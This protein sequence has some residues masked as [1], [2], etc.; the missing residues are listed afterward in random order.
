MELQYLH[1]KLL[2][3]VEKIFS[4][5]HVLTKFYI[6]IQEKTVLEEFLQFGLDDNSKVLVM[7]CGSI[8]NTVVSL[9][10]NRKW[11]IVGIDRD[12]TAIENAKKIID[13]YGLKNVTVKRADGMEMDLKGY[14]LIVVALGIEPKDKVLERISRDADGGTYILCRTAGAFSRIFGKENLN[15]DGLKMVKRYRRKD[16]TE[17]IVFVKE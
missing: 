12:K 11:K 10:R 16:G 8:P 15:I 17:S 2:R 4:K 7:G 13:E 9:A 5:S 1:N 6:D 14:N 3:I